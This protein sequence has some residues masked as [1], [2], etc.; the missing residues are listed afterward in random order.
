MIPS[1]LVNFMITRS[2]SETVKDFRSLFP[3]FSETRY[4][5][6]LTKTNQSFYSSI[7]QQMNLP[8]H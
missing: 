6:A 7:C 8:L 1:W 3:V 4:H 2:F 5:E